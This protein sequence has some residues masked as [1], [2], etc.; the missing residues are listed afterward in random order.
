[1]HAKRELVEAVYAKA[2]TAFFVQQI[3]YCVIATFRIML[4]VV[5][6]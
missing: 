2:E 6:N 1:M 4:N 3:L 5:Y